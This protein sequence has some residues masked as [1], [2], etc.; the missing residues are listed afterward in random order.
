MV[1]TAQISMTALACSCK[2]CHQYRYQNGLVFGFYEHECASYTYIGK[3]Q[4]I[5]PSQLTYLR[6]LSPYPAAAGGAPESAPF[7]GRSRNRRIAARAR[8]RYDVEA[9]CPALLDGDMTGTWQIPIPSHSPS[10][11]GWFRAAPAVAL[12]GCAHTHDTHTQC[13]SCSCTCSW[14][15]S[16]PPALLEAGSDPPAAGQVPIGPALV[17]GGEQPRQGGSGCRGGGPT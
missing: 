15:F 4:Y 6:G 8:V 12:N 3:H 9:I 14:Y 7:Y 16:G 13:R 2:T 5:Q 17:L 10:K 11:S 1:Q